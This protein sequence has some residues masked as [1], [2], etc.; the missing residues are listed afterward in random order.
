MT[1]S[2]FVQMFFQNLELCIYICIQKFDLASQND[3][4]KKNEQILANG[5]SIPEKYNWLRLS[6]KKNLKYKKKKLSF[7]INCSFC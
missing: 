1:T 5:I 2:F 4:P 7:L 6:K 3:I